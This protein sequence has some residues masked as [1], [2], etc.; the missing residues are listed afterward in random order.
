MDHEVTRVQKAWLVYPEFDEFRIAQPA[1]M[2]LTSQH[3]GTDV[4]TFDE[5]I[6]P[7]ST[8]LCRL[9]EVG[10]NFAL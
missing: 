6:D 7:V 4:R 10:I 1:H 3:D 2:A 8:A 5:C 9:D